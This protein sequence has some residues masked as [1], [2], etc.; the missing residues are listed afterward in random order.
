MRLLTFDEPDMVSGGTSESGGMITVTAQGG[1]LA[2]LSFSGIPMGAS[3]DISGLSVALEGLM[4]SIRQSLI[5]AGI[6]SDSNE[7]VSDPIIVVTGDAPMRENLGNG[8]AVRNWPGNDTLLKDGKFLAF[9][10]PTQPGQSED[11]KFTIRGGSFSVEGGKAGTSAGGSYTNNNSV[12]RSF[13]A[14]Q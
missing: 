7:I 10:N 8:Y 14:V 9:V 6:I 11:W 4:A 13:T 3:F 2:G 1:S 5:D 12:E